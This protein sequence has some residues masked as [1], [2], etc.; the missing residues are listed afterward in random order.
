MT[1]LN[2]PSATKIGFA[3][4]LA[5]IIFA[6]ILLIV[7]YI[8]GSKVPAIGVLNTIFPV[9]LTGLY[10][11]SK[12]GEY[13]AS[14]TRWLALIFWVTVIFIYYIAMSYYFEIRLDKIFNRLFN[15]L[16]WYSLIILAVVI[17]AFLISYPFLKLGEKIG[18]KIFLQKNAKIE[19]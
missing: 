15:E 7:E 17:I 11:G 10:F 13:I 19:K 2:Q 18:I 14:R 16:G 9:M 4:C 6:V 3:L 5:S 12:S 8:V 1:L